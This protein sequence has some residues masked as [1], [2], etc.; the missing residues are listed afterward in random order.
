MFWN[1]NLKL[2]VESTKSAPLIK[3]QIPKNISDEELYQFVLYILTD[4]STDIFS[5]LRKNVGDETLI[6]IHDRIYEDQLKYVQEAVAAHKEEKQ[7]SAQV[8]KPS[9][10][11]LKQ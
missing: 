3:F 9:E 7:K 5:E 11:F 4:F 10:V 2:S 8:V 1:N 6:W